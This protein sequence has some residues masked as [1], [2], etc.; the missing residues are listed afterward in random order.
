MSRRQRCS[1][2]ILSLTT[3]FLLHPQ[4]ASAAA[5]SGWYQLAH[6]HEHHAADA[7]EPVLPKGERYRRSLEV[8]TPPDVTLINQDG[9]KVPF[10][11]ATNSGRPVL[12]NFLFTSCT[13]IC[14]PL[15]A[16][17][18]RFQEV[19]GKEVDQVSLIS[20]SIDPDHDTP[21]AMKKYLKRF[22]SQTGWEF[23]TGRSEDVTQVMK[24]FNAYADNKMNHF[25]LT[26]IH[27]PGSDKWV[28]LYG[29][30]G[31]SELV[32]EYRKVAQ[33]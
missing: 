17:F 28:R 33:P 29:L 24:A 30:L 4:F 16:N 32:S 21:A 27:G 25:P 9:K 6:G 2:V 23:L 26:F 12:L 15:A 22:G 18:A 8:Y 20:V 13:T 1:V 31:T 19:L 3:V 10:R 11:M 5:K 7:V 14:P